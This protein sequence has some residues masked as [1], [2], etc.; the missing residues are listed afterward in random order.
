MKRN[1]VPWDYYTKRRKVDLGQ[2]LQ[3]REIKSYSQLQGVLD[4][5]GVECPSEKLYEDA[6]KSLKAPKP[7]K[8]AAKP[9]VK[10]KAAPKPTTGKARTTRKRSPVVKKEA[11]K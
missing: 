7:K 10:K 2:Y 11:S 5:A 3:S 6:V 9:A 1:L 4:Q 8:P